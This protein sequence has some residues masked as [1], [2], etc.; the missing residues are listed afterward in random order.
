M[1]TGPRPL[2][3]IDGDPFA[4]R[5]FHALPK[6]IR[7]RGGGGAIVGFANFVIRLFESE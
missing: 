4:H 5:S 7:H 6:S 3:V 1:S 2:L